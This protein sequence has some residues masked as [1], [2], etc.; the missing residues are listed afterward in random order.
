LPERPAPSRGARG[1]D[2][3]RRRPGVLVEARTT[4]DCDQLARALQFVARDDQVPGRQLGRGRRAEQ[5]ARERPEEPGASAQAE[6]VEAAYEQISP[7]LVPALPVQLDIAEVAT[8][9]LLE[10]GE[11]ELDRV[12]GILRLGDGEI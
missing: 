5:L 1:V 9:E 8:Q 3:P 11:R 6:H 12:V 7:C 4:A 10:V 2:V